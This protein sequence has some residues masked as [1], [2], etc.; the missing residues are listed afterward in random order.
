MVK[1]LPTYLAEVAHHWREALLTWLFLGVTW[2]ALDAL[3]IS[4]WSPRVLLFSAVAGV[5]VAQFF[6][7]REGRA[8]SLT[9]QETKRLRGRVHGSLVLNQF[10]MV[11]ATVAGKCWRLTAYLKF[12]NG[13][14]IPIQ[15]SMKV[16]S[17]R[18]EGEAESARPAPVSDATFHVW[19]GQQDTFVISMDLGVGVAGPIGGII[20]Y[21]AE[22]GAPAL[23]ERFIQRQ[24][25]RFENVPVEGTAEARTNYWLLEGADS[26]TGD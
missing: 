18:I 4:D 15:Y 6:A 10:E 7:W 8:L 19:P 2:A 1:N 12:G 13:G 17:I 3:N 23:P 16:L 21:V 20:H 24:T 22:Y 11:R 14:S 5:L 9:E 25:Y 26:P